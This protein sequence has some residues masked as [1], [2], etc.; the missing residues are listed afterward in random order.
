M[1]DKDIRTVTRKVRR[2]APEL[3]G[4]GPEVQGAILADLVSMW[5]AGHAPH[6]REE[7][8]ATWLVTMRLLVEPNEKI[9]FGEGGHP[10]GRH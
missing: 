8:L 6:V 10:G 7:V 4:L 9:V 3:H 5:M 1:K 2:L